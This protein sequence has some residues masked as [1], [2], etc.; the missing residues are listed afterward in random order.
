MPGKSLR[1][2]CD[3]G[4][5]CGKS[6][7]FLRSSDAKCQR[8]G[9]P[10][11]FGLRCERPRCQIAS[12]V[13]RAMRTT[14]SRTPSHFPNFSIIWTSFRPVLAFWASGGGGGNSFQTLSATLGPKGPNDSCGRQKFVQPNHPNRLRKIRGKRSEIRQ[15]KGTYQKTQEGCGGLRG[16]NSGA[17]P[18]AGP[19]FQQP[20]SLPEISQTLAGIAF[21]AARKNR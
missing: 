7:C 8:F 19:I 10:L 9:L 16:E 2:S 12:D 13:G 20:L 5:R 21:R 11:R 14:K 3:V 18:K 17:F 1:K 6:G 15:E 4:L